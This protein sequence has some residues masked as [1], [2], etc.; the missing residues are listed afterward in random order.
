MALFA[1]CCGCVV[2]HLS[3][4]LTAPAGILCEHAPVLAAQIYESLANR[5]SRYGRM[6]ALGAICNLCNVERWTPPDE[7]CSAVELMTDKKSKDG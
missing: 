7:R 4:R 3:L 2:Q 5:W 6:M 1:K